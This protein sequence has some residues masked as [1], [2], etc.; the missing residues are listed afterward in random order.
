M[1]DDREKGGGWLGKGSG[2]GRR[3]G[4]RRE[5]AKKIGWRM[6]RL[7]YWEGEEDK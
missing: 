2:I 5:D 6:H 4:E 3:R 7:I 1:R